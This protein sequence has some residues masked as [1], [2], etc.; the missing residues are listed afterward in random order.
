MKISW[1]WPWGRYSFANPLFLLSLLL[2]DLSVN[3]LHSSSLTCMA[4]SLSDNWTEWSHFYH[5]N[6]LEIDGFPPFYLFTTS[7]AACNCHC[8]ICQYCCRWMSFMNTLLIHSLSIPFFLLLLSTVASFPLSSI[9][10][11]LLPL[12]YSPSLPSPPQLAKYVPSWEYHTTMLQLLGG[13][14]TH[15]NCTVLG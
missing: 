1:P 14:V 11:A 3:P 4:I 9:H 5:F 7:T 8:F 2:F 15:T 10:H 13:I 6:S 12:L